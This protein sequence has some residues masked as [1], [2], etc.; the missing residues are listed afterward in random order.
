MHRKALRLWVRQ[1]EAD[2]GERSDLLNTSERDELE[3]LRAE[4]QELRRANETSQGGQRPLTATLRHAGATHAPASTRTDTLTGTRRVME[5][6]RPHRSEDDWKFVWPLIADIMSLCAAT[7][8]SRGIEIRP[9][10]PPIGMIPA[11]ARARRRVYQTATLADDRLLVTDLDADSQLVEKPITPGSAAD[12]GERMILEPVALNPN[13]RGH[14]LQLVAGRSACRGCVPAS[15]CRR[16]R[17]RT[18]DAAP[19]TRFAPRRGGRRR[20]ASVL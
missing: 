7:V 8:T 9:P 17:P 14:L 16:T 1:A 3:R 10:C 18:A 13:A 19:P 6:L 4:N 5:H 12:L 20:R 15:S 11:F 2:R